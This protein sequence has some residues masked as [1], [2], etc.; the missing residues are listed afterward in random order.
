MGSSNSRIIICNL[1]IPWSIGAFAISDDTFYMEYNFKLF[2]WKLGDTEWYD[3]E[4]EETVEL[5]LNIA[6]RDLKLATSGNTV[7]V[8]KRDGHLVASFDKGNNWLD[9]TPALPF[10]VKVFK[11]IV[12]VGST[13]YVAT[14]AGVI[15]S[16]DGKNWKSVTDS[17]G[18]N[19]IMEHLAV[20]GTTL[21][22][23]TENTGIY[24]LENDTWKQIVSEI[25][26]DVNSLAV[27]GDTLYV[28]TE[29][30]GMLHFNLEK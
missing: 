30:S 13:V 7:Y 29:N 21:Y 16:D 2:R 15:T 26:N 3:T 4:Q 18:T 22:G 17:E 10:P 14:D 12:F 5:T 19:L 24:Q 25:P 1:R 11:E 20:D 23:V 27:N 9:L 28:G 8:G 6:R